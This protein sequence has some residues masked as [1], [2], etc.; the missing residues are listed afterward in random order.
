MEEIWRDVIGYE[1]LYKVSN[2]GNIKTLYPRKYGN[3]LQKYIN[4]EGYV[5]VRLNKNCKRTGLL[6]HRIV[7]KAFIPNPE[8]KPQVNHIDGNKLNN[9]VDNLEW[10][11]ASENQK[12][13]WNNN[14]MSNNTYIKF[15]NNHKGKCVLPLDLDNNIINI[16]PSLTYA[17][18]LTGIK[19]SNISAC[20]LNKPK[21]KTAGG[22]IWKYQ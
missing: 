16:Y 9:N 20:C 8:N 13:S 1:D 21:Y 4:K 6:L 22:Y 18:K 11:T 19:S 15:N 3:I 14:L 12:H 2:L 5:F 10:V 7:A 17:S